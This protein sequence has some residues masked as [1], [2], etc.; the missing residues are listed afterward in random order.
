VE[1]A[2]D[3]FVGG[4]V[5]Y[6]NPL[7][8]RILG[9]QSSVLSSPDHGAVSEECARQMAEGCRKA[10]GCDAGLATTGVAGVAP[11]VENGV[12]KP[13]GLVIVGLATPEGVQARRFQWGGGRES[14]RCRAVQAA[15]TMLYDWLH[16]E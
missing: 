2:S 16:P 15:L 14:V 13:N 11:F 9:V 8:H 7:K 1:G 6:S 3:V 12:A 5:A 10:L 4:V